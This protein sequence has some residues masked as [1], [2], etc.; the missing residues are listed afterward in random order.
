MD[1]N[2]LEH[3]GIDVEEA[4]ARVLGNEQLLSRLLTMFLADTNLDA[5]RDAVAAHDETAAEAASHALKGVASNLSIAPVHEA[6]ARICDLI[7]AG[8]WDEAVALVEPLAEACAAADEAI[9]SG[10]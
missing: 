3:G 10:A 6:S 1:R 8:S 2:L 4:L 7:R 9:R 5:L